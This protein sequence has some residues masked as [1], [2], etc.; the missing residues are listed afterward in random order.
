MIEISV[1]IIA[2]CSVISLLIG[3]I[4]AIAFL[5]LIKRLIK[6]FKTLSF[7]IQPFITEA[8]KTIIKTNEI[9]SKIKETVDLAEPTITKTGRLMEHYINKIQRN[10]EHSN[11]PFYSHEYRK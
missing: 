5:K 6:T 11:M 8:N 3:L 10:I 2:I 9:V 1:M 7:Q 4:I